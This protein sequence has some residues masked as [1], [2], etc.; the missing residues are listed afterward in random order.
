MMSAPSSANADT[1]SASGSA[2]LASVSCAEK[3]V[4]PFAKVWVVA[5]SMP[6]SFSASW[7]TW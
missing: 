5:I 2:F 7:K 1:T 4:S 6:W 3:S